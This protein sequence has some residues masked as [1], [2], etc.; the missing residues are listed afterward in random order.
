M[1]EERAKAAVEHLQRA[2]TEMIEATRAFLDVLED[3]VGDPTLVESIA[4]EASRT[5]ERIAHGVLDAVANV[6]GTMDNHGAGT[7]PP[8]GVEHIKVS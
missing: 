3:V 5:A 8:P 4:G 1:R 6:A 7:A 2:A